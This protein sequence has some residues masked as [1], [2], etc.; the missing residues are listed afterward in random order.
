MEIEEEGERGCD[1]GGLSWM[2]VIESPKA[3]SIV[4]VTI[5][6]FDFFFLRYFNRDHVG[7]GEEEENVERRRKVGE[8][9]G[10]GLSRM[11]PEEGEV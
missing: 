5:T 7:G 8:G 3:K 10:T 4:R 1:E 11:R 9:D 2:S 6:Y